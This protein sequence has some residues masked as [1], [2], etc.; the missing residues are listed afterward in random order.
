MKIYNVEI[1]NGNLVWFNKKTNEQLIKDIDNNKQVVFK[2]NKHYYV[3]A[4]TEEPETCEGCE[5]EENK[6]FQCIGMGGCLVFMLLNGTNKND[7]DYIL[8]QKELF[9]L[10]FGK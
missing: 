1:N 2:I 5:V 8:K 6:D 10:E 3:L 7:D 9:E 4:E